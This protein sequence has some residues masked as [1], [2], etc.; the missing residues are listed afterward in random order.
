MQRFSP[1]AS[2]VL[3][4]KIFKGF[5]HIWAWRPSWSM[6]HDHFSNFSFPQPKEAPHEIRAKLAQGLQ[7]RSRLKM[8]TDGRTDGQTDDGRKV[9]T[10]AHPEHSSGEL[11]ILTWHQLISRPM[12]YT[13]SN[14]H[15]HT[16][17]PEA[18]WVVPRDYCILVTY[19]MYRS[20]HAGIQSSLDLH[21]AIA[22]S[23]LGTCNTLCFQYQVLLL[24][25]L[26]KASYSSKIDILLS[27][28]GLIKWY[29]VSI[30]S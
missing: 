27:K 24:I 6:D 23:I 8:L 7:R 4:K 3:E 29:V 16:I 14:L 28:K 11:K 2:S 17:W 13:Y 15:I 21:C 9:I 20:E 10:I 25:S 30:Q 22:L 19:A 26:L 12:L 18:L 1:K 5:Y